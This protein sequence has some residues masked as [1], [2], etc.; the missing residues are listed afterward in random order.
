M[1]SISIGPLEG[2][3]WVATT[4]GYARAVRAMPYPLTEPA[5]HK[6]V[7]KL[8]QAL[9][10][11]LFERIAKDRV[12]LT[13]AG[14]YLFEFVGPFVR[15]LPAVLREVSAHSHGGVVRVDATGIVIRHL[16]PT[17]VAALA[18]S[19]PD[20]AVE[21][22]ETPSVEVERLRAGATDVLIDY[23]PAAP[24][25]FGA[26]QVAAIR[27][28]VVVP[29]RLARSGRRPAWAALEQVPFVSYNPGRVQHELQ[30]AALERVGIQPRSPL[31]VSS[32]G[33]ITRFVAAGVGWSIIPWLGTG[34]PTLAGVG[35]FSTRG[36]LPELPVFAVWR[37]SKVPNPLLDAFL[38]AAPGA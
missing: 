11:R 7:R 15:G 22:N 32:V 29:K 26:V 10:V 1:E 2:F 5:V 17:W 24:P 19:R 21:I 16:L 6:Q 20:I 23:Q 31:A 14:R 27:P 9:D 37:D 33:M 28:F 3:Y 25:D 4:G 34:R 8:E 35:A 38:G 12:Q 30:L 36:I 18:K 13:A